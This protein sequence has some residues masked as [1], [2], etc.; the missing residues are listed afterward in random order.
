MSL[1]S[2]PL[3]ADSAAALI[4]SLTVYN[5]NNADWVI[6][7]S[8]ILSS[9]AFDAGAFHLKF[10]NNLG[11]NVGVNLTVNELINTL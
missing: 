7:D 11:V 5:K 8:T 6:D 1:I 10:I 4:P 3:T 2:G 9:A